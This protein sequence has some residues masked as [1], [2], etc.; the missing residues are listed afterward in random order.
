[1]LGVQGNAPAGGASMTSLVILPSRQAPQPQLAAAPRLSGTDKQFR[2]V[3]QTPALLPT[4]IRDAAPTQQAPHP[5][6]ERC[7]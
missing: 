5:S 3:A 6:V 7:P 1:M 4:W 2:E